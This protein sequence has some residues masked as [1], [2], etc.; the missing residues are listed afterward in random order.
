M[1]G[2]ASPCVDVCRMNSETG[3]CDGCFRTINEI[4]AW[5]SYD[6]EKRIVLA[7]VESRRQG[8]HI[9]IVGESF[10]ATLALPPDSIKHFRHARQRPQSAASRRR[11]RACEPLRFTD[12]MGH[13]ADRA[14]ASDGDARHTFLAKRAAAR[15][16]VRYQAHARGEGR[17]RARDAL[18]SRRSEVESEA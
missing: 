8:A 18:A 9:V 14:S 4:A 12:R 7:R 17:R 6:D 1:S 11:L 2:V 16:R 13:A 3:F 5:A 10:E 15:P